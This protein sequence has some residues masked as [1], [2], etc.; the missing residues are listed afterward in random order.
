M[1]WRC[2]SCC[3][4]VAIERRGGR[5]YV[6]DHALCEASGIVAKLPRAARMPAAF[7]TRRDREGRALCR[8]CGGLVVAPRRTW[9]SDLCVEA[10][11]IECGWTS[12]IRKALWDRDNGI[13]A[14]CELDVKTLPGRST[15][16]GRW[17]WR[18]AGEWDE[19]RGRGFDPAASAW[20]ADHVIPV[21]EGG[22]GCGLDGYRTLCRPCHVLVTAELR[23]R[24]AKARRRERF[25]AAG[26]VVV[27]RQIWIEGTGP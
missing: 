26:G 23:A 6:P 22:G 10:A 11:K 4:P 7:P 21:V 18:C 24:L 12:V 14:R 16:S 2:P 8:Y 20:E 3:A 15:L 9:C 5:A 1:I 13:C 19:L 27:P 17:R 25:E